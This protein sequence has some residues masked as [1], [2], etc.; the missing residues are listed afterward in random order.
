MTGLVLVGGQKGELYGA[1]FFSF[2]KEEAKTERPKEPLKCTS[3][4]RGTGGLRAS[5]TLSIC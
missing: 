1:A 2:K 3:G 4:A 5:L